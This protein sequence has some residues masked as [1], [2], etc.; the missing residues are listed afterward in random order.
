[1]KKLICWACILV[2][3][4]TAV[5]AMADNTRR[6]GQYTYQI[7]GNGTITITEFHWGMNNGDIY[8]PNMIDG[9]T[10]TAIGDEA[11]KRD[12]MRR[13]GFGRPKNDFETVSLT[14]PD[15]IKSIGQ[16]AF[17]NATLSEINLPDNVQSIGYGAFVGNPSIKFKISSKH[18]Y[19]AVINGVLYSKANKEL[20]AYTHMDETY[21]QYNHYSYVV[22]DGILSIGDYAFYRDYQAEAAVA[23]KNEYFISSERIELPASVQRIGDYAFSG[24]RFDKGSI[25]MPANLKS[26]GASAFEDAAGHIR[27]DIVIPSGVTSIGKAAFQRSELLFFPD[28]EYKGIVFP[29]DCA[30]AAIEEDTFR[31]CGNGI[32]VNTTNIHR[33]GSYAFYNAQTVD[34]PH[35]ES[36]DDWGEYAFSYKGEISWLSDDYVYGGENI[37]YGTVLRNC[38]KEDYMNAERLSMIF[39]EIGFVY[40]TNSI[41]VS[42]EDFMHILKENGIPASCEEDVARFLEKYNIPFSFGK[43]SVSFSSKLTTIPAG[44]ELTVPLPDTVKA[45]SS[46]AFNSVVTDYR[47]SSSLTN[48]AVDAFPKGSTFVVDEGSYA[49]LW[50]GENGF[51]YSIEGQDNLDWLNN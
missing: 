49:E 22:P 50:C 3:L 32:Y 15:S 19:F 1:M 47:L 12:V 17:W 2:M 43:N 21:N 20:L 38:G 7:K 9:Y 48:I 26:I 35:I 24:F 23:Y 33:V 11:F 30:V 42:Y 29:E 34:W 41:P 8:I 31:D 13:N 10:V 45:I 44:F 16:K 46:H 28:G 36:I 25:I 27:D 37:R 40:D 14:I 6:S 51:G 5:P 18:P 4:L 39:N